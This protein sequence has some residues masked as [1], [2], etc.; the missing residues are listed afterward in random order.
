MPPAR[1]CPSPATT[2][3][4][5]LNLLLWLALLP[6]AATAATFRPGEKADPPTGD[7][8][9]GLPAAAEPLREG[10]FEWVF[11]PLRVHGVLSLDARALRLDDGSTTA[12]A[13]QSGDAEWATYLWQPWFAQFRFGLGYVASRDLSAG[14]TGAGQGS[15]G[16]SLTGRL[17]TQLFPASRFPFELRADVSDSRAGG[18]SLLGDLRSRRLSLSQSY[19]PETGN[20]SYQFQLD[21]SRVD[22]ATGG[23]TLLSLQ[24][25]A[26]HLAGDH[27][28]ELAANL[29]NHER[30][31]TGDGTHVQAVT[32]RHGYHPERHLDIETLASWNEVRL[33]GGAPDGLNFGV[34]VRQVS[35]LVTWRP[36]RDVAEPTDIDAEPD[37]EAAPPPPPPPPA[38]CWWRA[39]RAGSNRGRAWAAGP[40]RR[41]V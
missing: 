19:R 26:V 11:A 6:G 41:R 24:G 35:T 14:A 30:H 32:A 1:R 39:V 36:G 21:H 13:V 2:A 27:R 17:S 28:F 29:S 38:R 9:A 22:T 31:D 18:D 37:P 8:S 12:Q 34:D 10:G 3:R 23:D 16:A 4:R 15:Q 7:L 33:R 25:T 5:R 40:A 20:D